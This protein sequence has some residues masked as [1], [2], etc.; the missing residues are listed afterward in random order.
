MNNDDEQARILERERAN[1]ARL[2]IENPLWEE[3]WI[4]LDSKLMTAWRKSSTG[5]S[6]RRELIYLQLTAAAEVRGHIE[7]VLET[8]RLAEMQLDEHEHRR[9]SG[10]D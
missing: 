6:E 4:A 3:A 10:A 1:K 9:N 5:A 8:G 7:T 2:I